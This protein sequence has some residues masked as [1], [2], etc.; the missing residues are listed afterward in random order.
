VPYPSDLN[1]EFR[2]VGSDDLSLGSDHN[3]V[4][5]PIPS[6][7][8]DTLARLNRMDICPGGWAVPQ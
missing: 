2:R 6:C 5:I 1:L 3:F 8:R 7:N 4:T